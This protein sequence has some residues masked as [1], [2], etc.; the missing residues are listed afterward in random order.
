MVCSTLQEVCA[1]AVQCHHDSSC[2]VSEVL[3]LLFS[4]S[5]SLVL[6]KSTVSI[7]MR[8]SPSIRLNLLLVVLCFSLV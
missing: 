8:E 1:L 3:L 5:V 4:I 2:C 6:T 7:G